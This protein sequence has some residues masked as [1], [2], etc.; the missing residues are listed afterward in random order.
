MKNNMQVRELNFNTFIARSKY[1]IDNAINDEKHLKVTRRSGRDFIIIGIE[2]YEKEQETL[3]I[4]Q[5]P[6]I[7]KQIFSAETTHDA[8]SGYIPQLDEIDEIAGI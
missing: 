1:F 2:E 5:N 3:Y 7:M 4:L 8:N 6:M